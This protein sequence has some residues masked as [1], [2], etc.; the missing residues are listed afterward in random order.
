MNSNLVVQQVLG[1]FAV[2]KMAALHSQVIELV[3]DFGA[4]EIQFIDKKLNHY[5]HSLAKKSFP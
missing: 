2:G 1:K 4:F 3:R 5:A